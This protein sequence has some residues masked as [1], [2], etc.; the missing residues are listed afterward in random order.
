MDKQEISKI[1]ENILYKKSD[2]WDDGGNFIEEKNFIY[3][4]EKSSEKIHKE[5]EKQIID[6]VKALEAVISLVKADSQNRGTVNC[7]PT[8][9]TLSILK[10]IKS[11]YKK[12]RE[13]CP[14]CGDISVVGKLSGG[15]E[16]K[17]CDYWFCY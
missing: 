12:Q 4:A 2:Y 10:R 5:Y 13:K 7:N 14:E 11:G 1:I 8:M 3:I 17:E 16:C 15:V 6:P 9:L